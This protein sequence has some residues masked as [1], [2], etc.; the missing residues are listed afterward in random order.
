MVSAVVGDFVTPVPL[1][2]ALDLDKTL[3]FSHGDRRR[4]CD[5][6]LW[7]LQG[8]DQ[9]VRVQKRPGV[10]AFLLW[11]AQHSVEVSVFSAATSAYAARIVGLLDPDGAIIS[12]VRS[13]E[14]CSF[15]AQRS[16]MKDVSVV[17]TVKRTVLVD[18][19]IGV[20][21]LQPENGILVDDYDGDG[22]DTELSRIAS[23]L[24]ELLFVEDVRDV[25]GPKFA[26]KTQ[27]AQMSFCVP[28]PV[29]CTDVVL[30]VEK[31]F[32]QI[33][34]R[35]PAQIRFVRS[36]SEVLFDAPIY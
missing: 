2:V 36:M 15:C 18:N 5:F 20:F 17:G 28:L 13:R 21:R 22:E 9:V 1:H 33:Q 6:E 31:L 7:G 11:L 16:V 10:D 24:E 14:A 8:T 27:L 19:D 30:A 4:P 25:L 12:N 32:R 26:L 3:V 23:V 35:N 29:M 34:K